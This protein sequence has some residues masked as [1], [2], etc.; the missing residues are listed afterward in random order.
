MSFE[1]PFVADCH[2]H[3]PLCGHAV[4]EPRDYVRAAR[5]HGLSAITFTCHI[6][7]DSGLFGARRV[8]MA[9]ADLPRYRE[10]I[11]DARAVGDEEGVTVLYGIE[12]EVF[13]EDKA[14]AAMRQLL[15]DEPFDF[16]LGSLHHQLPI[17]QSYL[18]L[19]VG[20]DVTRIVDT[21]F[22]NLATGVATGL[23]DSIAHPDL[24]RIYGTIPLGA[25][26]PKA[27]EASIR[28]FL[29]AAV[30]HDVCLEV[31]TSGLTKEA[32]E[33]HPDP[34]ILHWAHEEGVRLTLGSDSH[35]PA[36]VGQ[37]FGDVMALLRTT[38][39]REAHYFRQ[40]QRIA[41]P[42]P[43]AAALADTPLA[44]TPAVR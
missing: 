6:P 29:Q 34:L 31:N 20:R 9:P 25:F 43:D 42:L 27:H 36:S 4:G 23:Y 44:P 22:A 14:L 3:T 30:A 41:Y 21:Y 32:F 2:M 13:P 7:M 24:I 17:Y 18:D 39:F 12:A 40:R 5:A 33:V 1:T 35:Q 37:H 11:A 19:Q 10:L 16:V 26:D 28:A 15:A 8:R 38:G